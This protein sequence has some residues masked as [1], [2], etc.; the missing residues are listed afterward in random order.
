MRFISRQK[1]VTPVRSD[2]PTP[3]ATNTADFLDVAPCGF[4]DRCFNLKHGM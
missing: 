2:V 4:T 3:V 1:S